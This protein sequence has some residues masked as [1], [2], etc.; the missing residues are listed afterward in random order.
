MTDTAAN[1]IAA[2]DTTQADKVKSVAED[3][4]ARRMFADT[5]AAIAYLNTQSESLPDFSEQT[6]IAKG[7]SAAEDGSLL[8]DPTVYT[9]HMRVMVA[10]LTQRV[11]NDKNKVQAIVIT[12]VPTV[13]SIL[14][15]GPAAMAWV[16]KTLDKELNHVAVRP[17]RK[18][19]EGSDL[20]E[21]SE[22]MPTTLEGYITSSRE[23]AGGA[24]ETFNDLARGLIDS[25]AKKNRAWSRARLTKQELKAA[26]ASRAFAADT[27]PALED[28][29]E[30]KESL[31]VMALNFGI[32]VATSKGLSV[33]IFERWL[34]Q[35]DET[36]LTTG[37]DDED[38]EDIDLDSLTFVEKAP[39]KTE[40][41]PAAAAE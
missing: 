30:G 2:A 5:T 7:V 6:I 38:E 4:P 27:Y 16:E 32:Q 25:L 9:E 21:L 15:G 3:M 13:E 33:E 24:I 12:P 39:A 18:P 17:L 23:T 11:H 36:K 8:F 41:A 28:R 29:G 40:A 22:Q 35:R 14:A 31:F 10:V 37:A 34:L 20:N 1:Q 19:K 26:M